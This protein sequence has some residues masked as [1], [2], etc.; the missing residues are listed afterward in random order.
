MMARTPPSVLAP[1]AGRADAAIG[2]PLDRVDGQAKVTG[3][4]KYAAEFAVPRLAHAVMALSTV[5][6]GRITDIDTG[7][8][9]AAPGVLLV[10]THRNASH[11]PPQEPGGGYPNPRPTERMLTLLQ[12]DVVRYNNEPIAVVVADT[13]EHARDAAPLIRVTYDALPPV[14]NMDAHLADAYAPKAVQG[15]PPDTNR[16]DVAAGL[17]SAA[18][19]L[20]QT[21]TTPVENHNPMEPHATIAVWEGDHLTLYDATQGVHPDRAT[22]AKKLGVPADNVRVIAKYVGGGFGCKGS[23]WS[24]VVLA[25]MAARRLRRP[26]KLV[27]ARQQMYGPVGYRP[28]TVQRIALGATTDGALTALRHDGISQTSQFDEFVEPVALASRML[29][30][31]P[32][33]STSH[34]LV[35]L[36]AGTPTFMR[37]PGEASGTFAIESAMDE[38]AY[39]LHMD[40]IAFRLKNYAETDPDEGRPWSS[41]S[42][43]ECY[44]RA[45]ERFGWERRTPAPRSMRDQGVLVGMGMATATYPTR[46]SQASALARLLADGSAVVLTGSQDIGTGTYTVM[47]QVAADGLG[48]PPTRVRV[49]IGDTEFPETPVSGGSQTAAT[50]GSAVQAACADARRNLVRL[51][52][53]DDVSPLYGAAEDAVETADGRL[54][55]RDQPAK[56]ESY[57]EVLRRHRMSQIEGRANAKPGAEKDQYSMHSFGAQFAEVRVDPDLGT[58]RLARFVGVYGVGRLL[59]AKTAHSQLLG[60]VVYG[61]GMALMEETVADLRNGRIVNADLAEYHV[62]VNLDIPDVDISFVDEHDAY[63]NPLGVKGIGEIGVTGVPAAIANAVF[64]ATGVRVRDLPI[65][66]DKLL[67]APE[68]PSRVAQRR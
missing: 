54:F 49:D 1:A 67:V 36:N 33:A 10:L 26:V 2:E 16:G 24:H 28:R 37:A 27:L 48:L 55:L 19:R 39:A 43:R 35:R 11:V 62:P 14:T 59:N 68:A 18:V 38:L 45:A 32:N 41:K 5:G 58:V 44:H 34:R 46:R 20:E 31:C 17:A 29:Y 64:H 57:G 4:A 23:V 3:A 30:A 51:A 22:V 9:E 60:G 53:G 6:S 25:A 15:K 12:D 52:I 21:Y 66:L 65:T 56:G 47:T 13:F 8:A 42:L 63:V 61:V 40:P 50:T 7:A